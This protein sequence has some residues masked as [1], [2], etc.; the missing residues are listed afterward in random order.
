MS[1]AADLLST[2]AWE[3]QSFPDQGKRNSLWSVG[4]NIAIAAVLMSMMLLPLLDPSL[5][6]I[7]GSA[8]QSTG[9][10]VQHLVLVVGML[11]GAIAAREQRLLALSNIAES[12]LKGAAK[13]WVQACTA[14]VSITTT[15]YLALAAW[16]FVRTERDTGHQL[17]YG[18]P[19][20]AVELLL[21]AGFA[22]ITLRIFQHSA[23]DWTR[24]IS[25]GAIAVL[26][27]LLI[28]N[29]ST[30]H[31]FV[32]VAM[33]VLGAASF[34]GVPALVSLGG[35]ALIL[36]MGAHEPIASIAVEHYA[37]VIN[38][39]LPTLPLF[40]LAGYFL[41]EG[42]S[43]RRL[44]RLFLRTVWPISRRSGNRHGR[45]LRLFTSVTG[46]SGVTILALGGLL[47]PILKSGKYS[48][49]DALG[50]ITGAGS[51]GL[52]LP[53]C[54][55][56]IVYAIVAK[57]PIEKMFSWRSVASS[58][59]D[60]GHVNLGRSARQKNGA[61][62]DPLRSPRSARSIVGRK[63]G[64]VVA[65]RRHRRAF[66]RSRDDGASG[67]AHLLLCVLRCDRDSSRA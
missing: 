20:W 4:E 23:R 48:E 9:S 65:G 58:R 12:R 62:G 3:T 37:L 53:P 44:I 55:P 25:C 8:A 46:A 32:P 52:L 43:P 30:S 10:I 17:A 19:V 6:W 64:T 54:L 42:G 60:D 59:D 33:I 31:L 24:R 40:T 50:M 2:A 49:K 45:S 21:P 36:F 63:V 15:S 56:L 1:A 5:R 39:V 66:Q 7:F 34:L 57:V 26:M 51:L 18:I 38:P 11:G 28:Q 61:N 16:Q 47:V 67:C 29:C 14:A 13:E 35:T 27:V 41:A 22:V